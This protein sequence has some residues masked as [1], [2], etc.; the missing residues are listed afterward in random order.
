MECIW[1]PPEYQAWDEVIAGLG[2]SRVDILLTIRISVVKLIQKTW[3][4]QNG[5]FGSP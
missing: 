1:S 4:V 2:R 5:E 3:R